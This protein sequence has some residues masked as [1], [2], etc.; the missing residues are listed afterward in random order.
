MTLLVISLGMLTSS[1][2]FACVFL[3]SFSPINSSKTASM[4]EMIQQLKPL[5]VPVPGGFTITLAVYYDAVLDCACRSSLDNPISARVWACISAG[6]LL[7]AL[8]SVVVDPDKVLSQCR[9]QTER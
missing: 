6:S 2:P 9:P 4:G 7:M 3:F 8:T 1:R 5:G